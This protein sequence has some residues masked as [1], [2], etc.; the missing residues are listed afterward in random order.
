MKKLSY[1]LPIISMLVL[2]SQNASAEDCQPG[3]AWDNSRNRC[4]YT[5]T[6]VNNQSEYEN[7]ENAEN[8]ESCI[9]DAAKKRAET[10]RQKYGDEVDGKKVGSRKDKSQFSTGIMTAFSGI[11]AVQA[12]AAGGLSGIGDMSLSV[13]LF[14]GTSIAG[15]I[16]STWFEKDVEKKTKEM[17][18]KFETEVSDQTNMKDAQL[19]SFDYLEEEQSYLQKHSKEQKKYYNMIALGYTAASVAAAYE[20]YTNGWSCSPQEEGADGTQK[21]DGEQA[22]TETPQ[23]NT[24]TQGEGTNAAKTEVGAGEKA[25]E[26][27]KSFGASVQNP[28]VVLPVG[29]LMAGYSYS[30][31]D[32]AGKHAK[33]AGENVGEIQVLKEKYIASIANYCPDGREDLKKPYCYCYLS[34][35]GKNPNREK[36]QTCQ[37]IWNNSSMLY[38]KTTDFL[39]TG[40]NKYKTGCVYV[41]GKFD[42]SCSCKKMK[43]SAGENAC[44]KTTMPR[45]VLS[46]FGNLDVTSGTDGINN[47][48][49]G[50]ADENA[51]SVGV[52]NNAAIAKATRDSLIKKLNPVLKKET[53]GS[54]DQIA[55]KFMK[56]L[57]KRLA[58]NGTKVAIFKDPKASMGS[59][60]PPM[61]G[62]E[63]AI[64][65]AGGSEKSLAIF[66]GSKK[67]SKKSVKKKN[68][69]FSFDSGSSSTT[70]AQFDSEDETMKKKYKYNNDINND[71]EAS[72]FKVIS[73]RYSQS[74]LKRLF[75]NELGE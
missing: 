66:K 54:I 46:S 65:K 60:R 41:D 59:S 9:S 48:L 25:W 63:K 37:N 7:C 15:W 47:I 67:S 16:K 68:K 10:T 26:G 38:A 71:K 27:L 42:A 22:K 55:D 24:G 56:D 1:I 57:N 20:I 14:A 8:K 49:S 44:M 21:P 5:Q 31:A 29:I 12:A 3:Y 28:C 32:E 75:S 17:K 51:V 33:E 50:N 40:G 39:G 53:G 58:A 30:L 6:S 74:G 72:I 36:S 43:N 35:G 19:R 69:Y 62:L 18:D 2:F 13:K 73:N 61:K 70:I 23:D 45:S 11:A 64:K 4:V 34:G 52:N